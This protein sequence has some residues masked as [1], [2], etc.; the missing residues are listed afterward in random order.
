[1]AK[2]VRDSMMASKLL[3]LEAVGELAESVA[4]SRDKSE[5]MRAP[6]DPDWTIITSR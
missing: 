1:M 2:Q 6:V 3:M 5:F 4:T